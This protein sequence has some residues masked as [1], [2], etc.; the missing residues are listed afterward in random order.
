MSHTDTSRNPVNGRPSLDTA[1]ARSGVLLPPGGNGRGL[2]GE[3]A[4]E[5]GPRFDFGRVGPHARRARWISGLSL[6]VVDVGV[7]VAAFHAAAGL[8]AVLWG[9]VGTPWGFWGAILAWVVLRGSFG[10]YSS[11]ALP[12]P[13]ELRRGTHATLL[14]AIFHGALLFAAE[15]ATSSR[16]V[17][18]GA[19]VLLVPLSW[20]GRSLVRTILIRKGTWGAPVFIV[21]AGETGSRVIRELEGNPAL[22]LRPVG[23]FDDDPARADTDLKGVPYLGPLD[24]ALNG[25]SAR[26]VRHVV[27]AMPGVDADRMETLVDRFRVR[28]RRVGVVPSLLGGANLWARARPLGPYLSVELR[29]DLLQAGN[30]RVKRA[31]DVIL[32]V[33]LLLLSAPIIAVA[34]LAV[35][36]VDRGSLFYAQEREGYQGRRFRMWKIRTMVADADERLREHLATHPEVR[37]EWGERMKLRDDPRIVPGVGRFLRRY[38]IDELPQLWNV[39][40]GDMSLVGPRPFPEYHLDR[41]PSDFRRLRRSVPPGVTGYWQVTTRSNGRLS[42]Q[43]VA[44]SYYIHNWSLWLDVWILHRTVGAV[45]S[46]EGAA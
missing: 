43:I 23:V 27:L 38:S 20:M 42:D 15:A 45:V 22:G 44:D 10:L 6:L 12:G 7:A 11:P 33:P 13:E 5:T 29:N 26:G 36:L 8:R 14:A 32:G 25:A 35:R 37:A 21:G 9:P 19:W 34:A 17:A 3:P 28:Y 31:F 18:F 2:A 16:F 1:E 40:R 41:F 24:V 39:V 46:G 30:L 4:P